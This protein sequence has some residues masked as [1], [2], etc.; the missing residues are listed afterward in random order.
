M[1]NSTGLGVDKISFPES[2]T[3]AEKGPGQYM[4]RAYTL[5]LSA[6]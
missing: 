1:K 6:F 5:N 3:T 4:L 2:F